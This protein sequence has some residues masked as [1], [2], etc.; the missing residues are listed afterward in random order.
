MKLA[1]LGDN[2]EILP[3][4]EAIDASPEHEIVGYRRAPA[5]DE[6]MQKHAI[7]ECGSIREFLKSDTLDTV[8]V[9]DAQVENLDDAGRLAEAGRSVLLWPQAGQ[10]LGVIYEISLAAAD[11]AIHLFPIWPL[12]VHPLVVQLRELVDEGQLGVFQY[13]ELNRTLAPESSLENDSLLTKSQADRAFL[14]DIDL[15]RDLGGDYCQVTTL[16]T[17]TDERLAAISTTLDSDQAPQA[18]WNCKAGAADSWRLTI[19]GMRASAVLSGD[20]RTNR[21]TLE[22]EGPELSLP[23]RT[24]EIDWGT[25][26][27]RL[28]QES[29][30]GAA[31]H[32]NWED[33][34]RGM[35]LMQATDRSLRRKR[36]IELFFEARSERSNFKTQMTAIGCGVILFTLVG[37]ILVLV[38]GQ[39]GV[40]DGVMH[41]LRIAVFAPLGIFLLL[42]FLVVFAKPATDSA[43]GSQTTD[44]LNSS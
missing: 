2:A 40:P 41:L 19:A 6:W 5:L 25:D 1:V 30:D 10:D 28:F 27:L 12:R 23:E 35:E 33:L 24:I 36:T 39:A 43:P 37:M 44:R 34:Q 14:A 18:I 7:A 22:V 20:P 16:R 29:V 26:V 15:L 31:V 3:L 42:Q 11:R 8:V 17:G 38:A 9:A 13:L 32:P 21:L 4:L